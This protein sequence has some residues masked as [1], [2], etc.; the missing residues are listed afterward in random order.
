MTT[1][2]KTPPADDDAPSNT[3]KDPHDWTTGDETMT[4]AQASYLKTLTEEAGEVRREA[5]EGGGVL[6]DR[7]VAE[8]DRARQVALGG[9]PGRAVRM[10]G[11]TACATGGEHPAQDKLP[12]HG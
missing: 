9:R 1:N 5:H 2:P 8:Q 7:R 3:V 12:R 11:R 6:E 10:T 4:G